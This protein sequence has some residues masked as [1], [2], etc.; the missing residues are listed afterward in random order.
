[1]TN[2]IINS[3]LTTYVKKAKLHLSTFSKLKIIYKLF[4]WLRIKLQYRIHF[5]K[6]QLTTAIYQKYLPRHFSKMPFLICSQWKY[7]ILGSNYERTY[8]K[9]CRFRVLSHKGHQYRKQNLKEFSCMSLMKTIKLS[10]AVNY[11]WFDLDKL[12]LISFVGR[13]QLQRS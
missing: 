1:M 8:Y 13:L 5:L 9:L 2:N 11:D 7:Y 10:A 12:L 6:N 3:L 4:Y